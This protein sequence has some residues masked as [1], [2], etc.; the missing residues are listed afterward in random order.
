MSYIISHSKDSSKD[1]SSLLCETT[2]LKFSP[3]EKV[4]EAANTAKVSAWASTPSDV[5]YFY[6]LKY[7]NSCVAYLC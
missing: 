1:G 6:F 4:R 5:G 7:E 3:S 2:F